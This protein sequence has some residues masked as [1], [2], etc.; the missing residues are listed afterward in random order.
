V[1]FFFAYGLIT[2]L[3]FVAAAAAGG[4]D[5]DEPDIRMRVETMPPRRI[6][7]G[8]LVSSRSGKLRRSRVPPLARFFSDTHLMSQSGEADFRLDAEFCCRR[9]S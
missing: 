5:D 3:A 6:L 8:S 7:V 1:L 9:F 2:T 4:A